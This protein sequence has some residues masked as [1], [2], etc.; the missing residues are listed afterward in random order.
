MNSLPR[1]R[2]GLLRH[3]LDGQVLIYDAHEDRVHLLDPTTGHVL[4]LLEEGGRSREGIVGELASRM[5]VAESDSLLQLSVEEL[6][7]AD[8]LDEGAGR[9]PA[10]SDLNRRELLRKVGLAGA[11]AVLIPAIATL[12]AT[13][14]YAQASCVSATHQCTPIF[15]CCPGLTCQNQNAFN[16]GTCCVN[17]NCVGG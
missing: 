12:T 3:Q 5:A 10:L 17:V 1:V 15:L 9:M 4:E 14:A 16:V 7:K 6:R 11:A 8:L 2:P 13:P